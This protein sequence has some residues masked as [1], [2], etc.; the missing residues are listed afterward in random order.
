MELIS[1]QDGP[2]TFHSMGEDDDLQGHVTHV[3]AST[4]DREVRLKRSRSFPIKLNEDLSP[5]PGSCCR[6]SGSGPLELVG[7][8]GELTDTEPSVQGSSQSPVLMNF[9]AFI[10]GEQ[11]TNRMKHVK[12]ALVQPEVCFKSSNNDSLLDHDH[13]GIKDTQDQSDLNG[14]SKRKTV[15]LLSI[16]SA[17][18]AKAAKQLG[19]VKEKTQQVVQT[20]KQVMS[21]FQQKGGL[22]SWLHG[23]GQTNAD[24]D[25]GL[26]TPVGSPS[27]EI[28]DDSEPLEQNK[29][30]S[31]SNKTPPQTPPRVVLAPPQ[32]KL[33][34]PRKPGIPTVPRSPVL[35]AA[36][37]SSQRQRSAS[38]FESIYE[39]MVK[40]LPDS[41]D[42][43][44]TERR[45]ALQP[46]PRKETCR[47]DTSSFDFD[48][49]VNSDGVAAKSKVSSVQ[50][51]SGLELT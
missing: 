31:P 30:E 32:F 14:A 27:K 8:D 5:H 17:A 51:I 42:E 10:S 39:K 36:E 24:C 25:D 19:H 3:P 37:S 4:I 50:H 23:E 9:D 43:L 1:S 35:H 7:C 16:K 13:R 48:D 15:G 34:S 6:E 41:A 22:V 40:S 12:E 29:S 28:H 26:T 46:S 21:V 11:Q 47:N 44:P 2:C 33:D 18:V 38:L 20:R 45:V 49:F